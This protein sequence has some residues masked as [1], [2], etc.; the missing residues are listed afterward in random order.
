MRSITASFVV[1]PPAGARVR[2][3]LRPTRQDA[4]VLGMVGEYLGG[5]AGSDLARRS[6]LGLVADGRTDRKRTLTS[7]SSSRWAGAITRTSNDQWQRGWRNLL[8]ARVSLRRAIRVIERRL[9][10]PAGGR[11]DRVH[12][13]P[14][15]AERHQ[16]QRRLQ[17]LTARL[18]EVERR[19]AA[20]RVSVCRGGRR[21]AKA[22]HHLEDASLTEQRWRQLWQAERWFLT[23]DG[24]ADKA[25]GNETIRVHSEAGWLE[26]KLP[27]PLAHL[28]NR[29]HGRYRLSCPVRFAHRGG[30]WAAQV[31]SG[32]VRYDVE[33][34]PD[35]GRW[36]LSASWRRPPPPAVT[37]QQ[38]VAGGVLAV[39]LNAGHLACWQVNPDGNPVGTGITIPLVLDGLPASTR[40]GRLRAA[41][42]TLLDL[43][44]EQGCSAVGIENLDFADVRQA[45]RET[46]GRAR[47]GRRFRRVVAGIPTRQF[48]DRLVQMAA[49]RGL[50][51]VAM[52]PGWTSKWG[53]QH[54]QRPLQARYP[55]RTIT[56]HHAA[57]VVLGRRALGLKARRRPGVPAPHQRMEAAPIGAGVESYRPGRVHTRVRA[58]HDPPATRPG[59]SL[60]LRKT[61]SGDRTQVAVQVAQDRSVSPVSADK[62]DVR[63]TVRTD[64]SGL[65][66]GRL[67]PARDLPGSQRSLVSCL[68]QRAETYHAKVAASTSASPGVDHSSTTRMPELGRYQTR[69]R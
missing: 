33:F 4:A 25:L 14:S 19:L 64:G 30:E 15:R 62:A 34:V 6:A 39:D 45:G 55:N 40:D 20:G 43:A 49:N 59:G 61:G 11:H 18:V 32:A 42:S 9:Q 12:G 63:G 54:W 56:R 5:L 50:A 67:L 53:G 58:G 22:R 51:V 66:G 1:A 3:R 37:V 29:P 35:R 17:H 7:A 2:T 44:T 65:P 27:A 23:A 57:C 16:K 47:R 36:Y 28:A 68:G 8:D 13:Y 38:A 52:D 48:R 24:E 26:L 10:A 41:I 60:E 21:L 31:A 46:L 69:C